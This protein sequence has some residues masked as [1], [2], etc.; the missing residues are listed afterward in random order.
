M[1]REEECW[2]SWTWSMSSVKYCLKDQMSEVNGEKENKAYCGFHV[3]FTCTYSNSFFFFINQLC[4]K[5]ICCRCQV[6]ESQCQSSFLQ[7]RKIINP[8]AKY[9]FS[10]HWPFWPVT[11]VPTWRLS[12]ETLCAFI[13]ENESSIKPVS[14]GES[15]LW[16]K[17]FHDLTCISPACDQMFHSFGWQ[18]G[19]MCV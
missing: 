7:Y 8:Q 14:H 18:G 1:R 5:K 10:L 12:I 4:E 2:G 6:R 3:S 9:P 13:R 15:W 19:V 17:W 16:L 11:T